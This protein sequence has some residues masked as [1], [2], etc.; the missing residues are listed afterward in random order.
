MRGFQLMVLVGFNHQQC[1]RS[2]SRSRRRGRKP[3][4]GSLRGECG[5]KCM[6]HGKE[7][8]TWCHLFPVSFFQSFYFFQI[9][10]SDMIFNASN[11]HRGEWEEDIVCFFL[12]S[13]CQIDFFLTS[14]SCKNELIGNTNSFRVRGTTLVLYQMLERKNSWTFIPQ[15]KL[16]W[17]AMENHHIF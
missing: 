10:G 5:E 15:E 13:K 8:G 14:R 9:L 16:R 4:R 11:W 1:Q 7:M 17:Q 12:F 6:E 3:W 2:L